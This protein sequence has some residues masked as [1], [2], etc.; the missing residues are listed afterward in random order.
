MQNQPSL[1]GS[2]TRN[3]SLSEADRDKPNPAR[4]NQESAT[5]PSRLHPSASL[6]DE[7]QRRHRPAL[8]RQYREI[9]NAR[10][11]NSINAL[12]SGM[13]E[14]IGLAHERRTPMLAS[15]MRLSDRDPENA[16]KWFDAAADETHAAAAGSRLWANRQLLSG[17]VQAIMGLASMM[18][19]RAAVDPRHQR[20][21]LV[22]A[23]S[24]ASMLSAMLRGQPTPIV[25]LAINAANELEVPSRGETQAA[26]SRGVLAR[27]SVLLPVD[28]V[29]A[30]EKVEQYLAGLIPPSQPPANGR[31]G[32]HSAASTQRSVPTPSGSACDNRPGARTPFTA[33]GPQSLGK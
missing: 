23:T 29:S 10:D 13:G 30:K 22:D 5:P 11:P 1:T 15:A 19:A 33:P 31:H 26:M 12:Y 7:V 28:V 24:R 2:T 21:H 18:R 14:T 4:N 25:A 8:E 17:E 6:G 20:K 27:S 9:L 32:T 3:A 16:A